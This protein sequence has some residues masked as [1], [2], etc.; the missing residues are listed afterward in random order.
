VG[1]AFDLL[2]HNGRQVS[3]ATFRGRFLLMFFGFTNCR[4][5][6]PRA[7]ERLSS[8]LEDLGA[9]AD[10]VQPLYVSVDPARDTAER[11]RD[12]LSPWPRFLGLTGSQEQI[13]AV[14]AVFRVFARRRDGPNGYDVPHSA[15][16]HLLDP[17]GRHIDYWPDVL[18]AGEI[19]DRLFI[20]LCPHAQLNQEEGPNDARRN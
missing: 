14:K 13:E 19:S 7:L 5:V 1:G 20:A 17:M 10:M 6:C 9:M 16:T 4:T 12:F 3:D 11:M 8:A 15:I 18:S 2:D